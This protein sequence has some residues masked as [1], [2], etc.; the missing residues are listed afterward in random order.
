MTTARCSLPRRLLLWALAL[1]LAAPACAAPGAQERRVPAPRVTIY[2]GDVISDS[3]LE[4]IAIPEN[5]DP[6]FVVPSREALVGKA[7]RRTLLPGKPIS[8]MAVDAPRL[9]VLG[10]Q[11]KLVFAEDGLVITTYGQALQ[12]GAAGDIVRVRNQ[13][14][15]LVVSGRVQPDGSIRVSEG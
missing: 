3:M 4:E 10:A 1:Q 8:P 14:S 7:A 13:D 6:A 15:G 2:P 5:A 11:V 12:N 9:V